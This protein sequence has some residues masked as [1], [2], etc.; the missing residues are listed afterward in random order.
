[1]Q[2]CY[3]KMIRV[4]AKVYI[5][6]KLRPIC[7]KT[8]S[9]AAHFWF[10]VNLHIK[11]YQGNKILPFEMQ[12]Q[13]S[14]FHYKIIKKFFDNLF[15]PNIFI[16][17][18]L[19]KFPAFNCDQLIIVR[20]KNF[21]VASTWILIKYSSVC[22]EKW[23]IFKWVSIFKRKL[24][25]TSSSRSCFTSR[26]HIWAINYVSCMFAKQQF[27]EID[28]IPF[29]SLLYHSRWF[30]KS[31]SKLWRMSTTYPAIYVEMCLVFFDYIACCWMLF[32]MV[33]HDSNSYF[34]G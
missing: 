21:L 23:V 7:L 20:K 8:F 19:S 11:Q 16:Q 9:L 1:M 22:N 34:V 15:I 3:P 17:M 24:S 6:R 28:G 10:I 32:T 4:W 31:Y 13:C 18:I 27:K 33:Y 14:C 5:N 25:F 2:L 12:Q 26:L 29:A 30:I